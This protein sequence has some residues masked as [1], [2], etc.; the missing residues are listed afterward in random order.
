MKKQYKLLTLILLASVAIASCTKDLDLVSGDT[1]TDG[2]FWKNADDF[3]K[4]ANSFYSSLPGFGYGDTESDI[5]FS[6]PNSL[7]NGTFQKADESSA[8]N[9]AYIRIRRANVILEKSASA[10]DEGIKRYAAEAKFFRAFNYWSLVQIFGGVPVIDKVYEPL[11][12]GLFAPR[13]TQSEVIDFIINDLDESIVDLP[14]KKDLASAD[15]GRI[16]KGAALALKAR[17]SLYQG[18]WEKFRNGANA[19]KYLDLAISASGSIIS[20]NEYSLYTGEG[21]QSYRYLFIEQGDDSPECILDRRFQREIAA[22]SFPYLL[23]RIGYNPTK[24]LADLYLDKNGLPIA[25]SAIFQGYDTYTSEFIDRDPRMTMTMIIP[26]TKTVRVFHPTTPV[27]NWPDSPQRN[28]N[29]GYILYKYMSE[30]AFANNNGEGG[31]YG[32]SHDYDNH[33]I[34]YA[35]VLLIYAEAMYEKN[36]SISDADLDKSINLLRDR[37]GMPHLT[38][39]FVA[40]NSLDMREEIRRERTVELA[41]EGFR[42]DDLLRWKTAETELPPDIKGIKIKGSDWQ[43]RAPYNLASYQ[44]RADANGFLIVES[45]RVFDASKHYLQPLPTKEIA[46]YAESG[47]S[48]EQNPNW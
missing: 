10:T 11:D 48:L 41:L 18:T 34:R 26:G 7:S 47:Y 46:F 2:S 1:L 13:S 15:V 3:K 21:V 9:N 5:A 28:P 8:W 6:N 19:S 12:P 30:D 36:G 35:E 24:K 32:G 44:N 27:E 37:V 20:S 4:A 14:L 31:T 39:S 16:T 17:V 25:K 38:N 23:D 45:A 40:A 42:R 22:H 33:L 29:T 43:N